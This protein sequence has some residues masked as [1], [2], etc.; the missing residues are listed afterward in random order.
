MTIDHEAI[1]ARL[2]VATPGPW[3]C[4]DT[5]LIGHDSPGLWM[6]VGR[7]TMHSAR[8][9]GQL[10]AHAPTDLAALLAENLELRGYRPCAP[11]LA[12]ILTGDHEDREWMAEYGEPFVSGHRVHELEVQRDALLAENRRHAEQIER[13]RGALADCRRA[14]KST[15][16]SLTPTAR[17]EVHMYLSAELGDDRAADEWHEAA[18][19]HHWG[20]GQGPT[21]GCTCGALH[22]EEPSDDGPDCL[23]PEGTCNTA[24]V[25][26]CPL[27]L[28]PEEPSDG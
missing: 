12:A 28:R 6:D 5:G 2:A 4:R 27:A 24:H 8:T 14:M 15:R 11:C 20:C 18:I 23:G 26:P 13:L 7:V 16:S 22:P 10:I 19:A 9:D 21:G 17:G 25:S 3:V 1:E